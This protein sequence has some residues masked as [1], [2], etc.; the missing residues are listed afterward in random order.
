MLMAVALIVGTAIDRPILDAAVKANS[1]DWLGFAGSIIGGI[2]AGGVAVLAAYVA[3]RPVFS[4]LSEMRRQ[5]AAAARSALTDATSELDR[6]LEAL[7]GLRSAGREADRLLSSFDHVAALGSPIM[8][9]GDKTLTSLQDAID[10]LNYFVGRYPDDHETSYSRRSTLRSFKELNLSMNTIFVQIKEI[11][12]KRD[13]YPIF[14]DVEMGFFKSK[15]RR[16]INDAMMNVIAH[17]ES[18]QKHLSRLW[19]RLRELEEIALAEDGA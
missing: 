8:E 11:V 5:T 15:L 12:T 13:V 4:Q 7:R 19:A 17:Q 1:E 3:A 10:D 16:E 9:M 6:E 2:L 14:N 18:T